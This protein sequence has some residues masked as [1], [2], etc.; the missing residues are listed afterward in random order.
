VLHDW[1]DEKCV[2]IL[3]NIRTTMMT[4]PTARILVAELFLSPVVTRDT[5]GLA[6]LMDLNMLVLTEQGRERTVEE[7]EDLY[8]RSGLKCLQVL[9]TSSPYIVMEVIAL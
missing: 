5:D 6:P 1:D 4:S 2:L 7:Y 3:K 8:S 9:R